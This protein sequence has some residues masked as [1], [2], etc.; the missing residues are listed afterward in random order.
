[1]IGA[2]QA[3]PDQQKLILCVAA[4]MVRHTEDKEA[5]TVAR[6]R[7]LY[8]ALAPRLHL[9]DA[10][11]ADFEECLSG[12]SESSL[13]NCGRSTTSGGAAGRSKKGERGTH[14]VALLVSFDDVDFA[15]S[16]SSPILARLLAQG[17]ELD[18]DTDFL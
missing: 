3:L 18:L 1:L 16:K 4:I 14:L 15:L 11:A 12:L 6:M 5:L 17:A 8:K 13:M 9:P 10:S 7:Q 2:M